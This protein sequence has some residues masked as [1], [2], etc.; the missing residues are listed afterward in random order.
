MPNRQQPARTISDTQRRQGGWAI[1]KSAHPNLDA[2]H[3]HY[4][5]EK[6]A[7]PLAEQNI[8]RIVVAQAEDDAAWGKPVRVRRTKTASTPLPSTLAT[9]VAFTRTGRATGIQRNPRS[10]SSLRT[11]PSN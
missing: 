4:E 2:A 10:P 9:R 5:Y 6:K 11:A 3:G 7:P 8:D 1:Q